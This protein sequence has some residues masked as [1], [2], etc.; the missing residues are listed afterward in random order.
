MALPRR[1][2]NRTRGPR[3]RFTFV[4]LACTA[5][6]LLVFD[7]PGTGALRPVRDALGTV[8]SPVRAAGDFVLRPVGNGAKGVAHYD[9]LRKENGR[10]KARLADRSGE[11]A[12][13]ARLRRKVRE[14]E[15]LNDLPTDDI[16][17]KAAMVTSDPYSNIDPT[18]EIDAGSGAGV[19]TGMAVIAGLEGRTGGG[20]LGRIDRARGDSS[21][22]M[23][24]TSPNFEVGVRLPD[25]ARGILR[26][27]GDDRALSVEGI[28]EEAKVK[29]GDLVYTSGLSDSQFPPDL[30]VGRVTRV[31]KS[32]DGLSQALDVD[33]MADRSSVYVRVVLKDPPR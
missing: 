25:G 16:S 33:P 7:V 29:R 20:L 2:T 14:L 17:T 22:V 18:L 12:E 6:T 32:A 13:L 26:G 1:S 8:L 30:V 3:S 5:L 24:A 11:E 27:Q 10:L 4:L 19:K 21:R 15:R 28:T 9:E 31:R 23:L